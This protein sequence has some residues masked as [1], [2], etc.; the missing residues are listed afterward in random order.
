VEISRPMNW[1]RLLVLAVMVFIAQCSSECQASQTVELEQRFWLAD[2]AAHG[3]IKSPAWTGSIDLKKDLGFQDTDLAPMKVLWH[4]NGNS[5]LYFDYF[6][7][8]YAGQTVYKQRQEFLGGLFSREVTYN[9]TE[10]L[11][12]AYWKVGWRK[13]WQNR[14]DGK[15]KMGF[16]LDAK[17]VSVHGS[18][19]VWSSIPGSSPTFMSGT[20]AWRMTLPTVGFSVTAQPRPGTKINMEVSGLTTGN[21]GFTFLDY[22]TSLEVIVGHKKN[23]SLVVGYRV[24]DYHDRRQRNRSNLE[25]FTLGGAF[26]GLKTSW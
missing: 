11:Q 13:Y 6:N 24:I 2:I 21:K 19:G 26:Y 4:I 8:Q 14:P 5:S 18:A 23:M 25:S 15:I 9:A 12:L 20:G 3:H 10:N 17:T 7:G 1:L 16:L 22:E